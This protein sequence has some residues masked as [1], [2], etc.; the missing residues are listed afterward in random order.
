MCR[1]TEQR[2]AVLLQCGGGHNQ[3]RKE[4]ER[5][6]KEGRIKSKGRRKGIGDGVSERRRGK[7]GDESRA[8]RWIN[9]QINVDKLKRPDLGRDDRD[10]KI[11]QTEQTHG[12]EKRREREETDETS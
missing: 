4:R 9:S 5:R 2:R 3:D 8:D 1:S 7:T 6:R 11:T 10:K 12:R